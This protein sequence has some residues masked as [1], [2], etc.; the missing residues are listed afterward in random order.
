[1]GGRLLEARAFELRTR[2]HAR[3]YVCVSVG[4]EGGGGGGLSYCSSCR[5][6]ERRLRCAEGPTEKLLQ[7]VFPVQARA[8]RQ[9]RLQRDDSSHLQPSRLRGLGQGAWSDRGFGSALRSA[10]RRGCRSQNTRGCLECF[11][12]ERHVAMDLEQAAAPRKRI[13]RGGERGRARRSERG[14]VGELG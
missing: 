3:L 6:G 9:D 14:L 13:R 12:C 10:T 11:Q 8:A 2:A 7:Q 1:M 5:A 4:G